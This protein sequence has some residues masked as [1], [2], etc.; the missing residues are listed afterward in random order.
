MVVIVVVV[1]VT[2]WRCKAHP[3]RDVHLLGSDL[4][5]QQLHHLR[6]LPRV[7]AGPPIWHHCRPNRSAIQA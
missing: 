3:A 7:H 2:Q 4:I 5:S 1:V 6:R